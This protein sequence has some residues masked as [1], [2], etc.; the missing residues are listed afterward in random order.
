MSTLPPSAASLRGAVDLSSLLRKPEASGT[1]TGAGVGGAAVQ[2]ASLVVDVTDATFGQVLELSKTVPVIVELHAGEPTAS[3]EKLV[4]SFA[5]RLV[6]ASINATTNPQLQQAFTAEV[7]PTVA[8]L[9]GGRP[10]AL[11]EGALPEAD[12]RAVLD[13]VL[14][15]AGQNNVV[16]AVSVED[17]DAVAA[18]GLPVE[19]PL[20]PFHQEA[21]DA[22]DRGD[23]PA[24]IAAYTTAIAQDP[25]DVLAVAGL[26]QV[27]LLNRLSGRT[28]V[29][30]RNIA[31]ANP[32]E[33]DAQ[34]AVADLD[35]SGGHLEDA[36]DRLLTLFVSLD[37]DGKNAVR[38]RMLE[39]FEVAG[40]DDPRVGAAR[41]RLTTLLY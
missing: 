3:L 24:A 41:R 1:E 38:T 27:S 40:A 21:Y 17:S 7:V 10:L 22:I 39:Y 23:Y 14:V 5:G 30:I 20:P 26:A 35:L 32:T 36:F 8:A 33:L 13:Q 37:Q 34:L 11:Y 28:A 19:V 29:D 16:G 18:V 2:V 4:I 25:R 12:A 9:V 31:G 6:L 15:I